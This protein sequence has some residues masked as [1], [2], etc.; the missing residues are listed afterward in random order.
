MDKFNEGMAEVS[1]EAA[2]MQLPVLQPFRLTIIKRLG[3][4]KHND[5]ELFWKRDAL[6]LTSFTLFD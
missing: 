6:G 4:E 3:L 2:T 1:I 5:P